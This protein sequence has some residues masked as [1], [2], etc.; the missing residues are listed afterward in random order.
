[1]S[2]FA[3]GIISARVVYAE[4]LARQRRMHGWS[5]VELADRCNYE[6]SYLH[7]LETGGRLGTLEAAQALDKVYGTG[8]H[9]ANLWRLAKEESKRSR[10]GN[11]AGVEANATKIQE[12]NGS[13]VPGL[14]QTKAYADATLRTAGSLTA[15]QVTEGVVARM[16]RQLVLAGSKPVHYR[17]LLDETV[18]QRVPLEPGVWAEQLEHLIEAA[19]RPNISLQ[20]VPFRVGMHA[21]PNTVLKLLWLP[22]GQNVAY[23]ENSW[24]GQ[25]VEEIEDVEQ[26]A[27]FYDQ[28]RDSALSPSESLELLRAKLEEHPSCPV[29]PQT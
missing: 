1:M 25:L 10:Y 24:S 27:L 16:N 13:A 15:E 7:R 14:L 2:S 29:P 28:L 4:E 23:V 21:L 22:S 17:A 5:L 6:Q 19:Q 8:K 11:F 3:E 18:L 20:I 12:F 26:L 9:L